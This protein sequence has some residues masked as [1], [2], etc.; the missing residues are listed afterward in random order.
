M[1]DNIYEVSRDEY[2]GV[3]SQINT[4]YANIE[5]KYE[6]DKTII[7]IVSKRGIDLTARIIPEEGEEQY[8]VF[9]LPTK[10]ESLPPKPVQKIVLVTH[11][12]VQT[13]FDILNKI[14]GKEK[15]ND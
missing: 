1:Y 6:E 8:Y 5:T 14:Q 3:V 11:E 15:E 9:N 4:A 13:F 12:E 2:A 7:K 10:E